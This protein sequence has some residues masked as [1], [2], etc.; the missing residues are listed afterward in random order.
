[1]SLQTESFLLGL[2]RIS[3]KFVLAQPPL[4]DVHG[5]SGQVA[6]AFSA[7]NILSRSASIDAVHVGWF[8]RQC[9]LRFWRY[10]FVVGGR[11]V[12]YSSCSKIASSVTRHCTKKHKRVVRLK[13]KK[14]YP[15]NLQIL[16]DSA[17]RINLSRLLWKFGTYFDAIESFSIFWEQE[18]ESWRQIFK[19]CDQD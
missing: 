3:V 17:R 19:N 12:R 2:I 8:S 7:G 10:A 15:E 5:F 6:P 11:S 14:R 9:V 16:R 13:K 18:S 4:Q 1:M